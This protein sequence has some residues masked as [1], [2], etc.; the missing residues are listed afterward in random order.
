MPHPSYKPLAYS[1]FSLIAGAVS[2]FIIYL[3]QDNKYEYQW[4]PVVGYIT[5]IVSLFIAFL[6][7]AVFIYRLYVK[8]ELKEMHEEKMNTL[9]SKQ[10]WEK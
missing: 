6:G 1:V 7:M 3:G 10:P 5:F 8:G 4:V 9:K 2:F